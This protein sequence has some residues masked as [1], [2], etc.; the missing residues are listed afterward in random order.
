M[1]TRHDLEALEARLLKEIEELSKRVATLEKL[2]GRK[3]RKT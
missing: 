1:V 3:R 2:M